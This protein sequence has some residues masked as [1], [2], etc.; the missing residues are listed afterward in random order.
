MREWLIKDFW[1]KLFSLFLAVAV[2]VTVHKYRQE[3]FQPGSGVENTYGDVLVTLV[4]ASGDVRDYRV[5]PATVSV[6]VSGSKNV[7]GILQANQI[8]AFV[9]L[10]DIDPDTKDS[11]R[12]VQVSTPTGVTL[13]SIDPPRVG[14]ILPPKKQ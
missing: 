6:T 5:A 11:R 13:V 1:W 4:S 12:P 9:D 3:N 10:T 2:W 8:H 14:I 7:M